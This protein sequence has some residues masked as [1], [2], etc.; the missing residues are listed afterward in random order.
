MRQLNKKAWSLI[1]TLCIAISMVIVPAAT[2]NAA[3]D[4]TGSTAAADY[5]LV[6]K[7]QDGAILHAFNWSYSAVKSNLQA[8]AQAGYS[9]VQVSPVQKPKDF[10]PAGPT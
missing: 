5:G 7:A 9:S 4:E 3:A 1:L 2:V 10:T 6:E 8:I